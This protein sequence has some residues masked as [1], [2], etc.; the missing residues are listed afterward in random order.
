MSLAVGVSAAFLSEAPTRG[1]TRLALTPRCWYTYVSPANT[2]GRDWDVQ[3]YLSIR[4]DEVQRGDIWLCNS[5]DRVSV[6]A[7][8]LT[9]DEAFAHHGEIT[10]SRITGTIIKGWGVGTS[11]T[12]VKLASQCVEVMR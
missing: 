7:V 5:E 11:G 12:W 6:S 2:T 9:T 1:L 3:E 10:V 8:E 4:A